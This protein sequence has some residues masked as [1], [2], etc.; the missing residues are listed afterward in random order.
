MGEPD[1]SVARSHSP[2]VTRPAMRRPKEYKTIAYQ[3]SRFT[4]IDAM[5]VLRGLLYVSVSGIA[6]GV[7]ESLS[8]SLAL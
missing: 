2:A 1:N 3:I 4:A 8:Y 6:L 5:M 7:H